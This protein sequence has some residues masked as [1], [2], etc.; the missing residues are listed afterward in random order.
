MHRSHPPRFHAGMHELKE[1]VA[2]IGDLIP[3]DA[4]LVYCDFPVHNNFGDILIMLGTAAFM[5]RLGNTVINSFALHAPQKIHTVRPPGTVLASAWRRK[6]RRSVGP[7]SGVSR[8]DQ[9]AP[10]RRIA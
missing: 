8:R 2:A 6:F 7:A 3:K 5:E 10:I 9:F 4:P 1:K